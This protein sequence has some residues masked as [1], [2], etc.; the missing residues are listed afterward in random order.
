MK[1]A[2]ENWQLKPLNSPDLPALIDLPEGG[3]TLGRDASNAVV[4]SHENHPHVSSF[5]ARIS[6]V[7]EVPVVED[8]G[9]SNGSLVNGKETQ[10][11]TLKAGDILQLGRRVGPRFLV[12]GRVDSV[13]MAAT[14]NVHLDAARP[15]RGDFGATTILHLKQ[16]LGLPPGD[17]QLKALIRTRSRRFGL[18][19]A[20]LF[21]LLVGGFTAGAYYLAALRE[22]DLAQVEELNRELQDRLDRSRRELRVRLDRS[23]QELRSHRDAW[24]GVR[25]RLEVARASL[26][27]RIVS[28]ESEEKQASDEM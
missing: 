9:S 20:L 12:V 13:D 19:L 7:D 4:F 14:V 11:A 16:A 10:Q 8:L 15:P 28:L 22:W 6:F 25:S 27:S 21:V 23:Q 18:W 17:V 5:H 26:Q 3:L 1:P 2:T 24:E